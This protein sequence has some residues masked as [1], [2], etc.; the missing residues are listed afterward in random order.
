MSDDESLPQA[1]TEDESFESLPQSDEEDDDE[2]LPPSSDMLLGVAVRSCCKERCIEGFVTLEDLVE[3]LWWNVD[4]LRKG[5][6][7]MPVLRRRRRTIAPAPALFLRSD[8]RALG[9]Q[10]LRH[11]QLGDPHHPASATHAARTARGALSSHGARGFRRAQGDAR[12]RGAR[13]GVQRAAL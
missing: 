3:K 7:G 9:S 8:P 10:G 6:T 4:Y 2:S 5:F 11:W 13:E 12:G 1:A